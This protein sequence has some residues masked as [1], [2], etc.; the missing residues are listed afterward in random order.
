[1]SKIKLEL[2]KDELL[3]LTALLDLKKA[4]LFL[5]KYE[6]G[7]RLFKHCHVDCPVQSVFDKIFEGAKKC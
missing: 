3:V 2:T 7:D 4:C 1:M 5:C 6:C